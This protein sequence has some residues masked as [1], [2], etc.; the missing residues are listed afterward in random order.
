M[1]AP[2]TRRRSPDRSRQRFAMTMLAPSIVVTIALLAFPLILIGDL[3]FRDGKVT[4][5]AEVWRLPLTLDNYRSVLEDS[6]TWSA[7]GTTVVYATSTVLAAVL[8]GLFAALLLRHK[9]P[10]RRF[11]RTALMIPWPV[12]GAI[13]SVAF[14]WMLDGTYGII[15]WMLMQIGVI[16]AP[17][18]WFFNPETALAGVLLP[19]TWIAYPVCLLIILTGV[20]GIPDE[21]YEAAQIDGAN[22]WQQFR[23]ITLPGASSSI[24]LAALI[25]AL[26]CFTTFDF[27][28]AI[29]RGGPN[30]ATETLAVSIYNTA[31]RAFDLPGA[32]ALGVFTITVAGALVLLVAPLMRKRFH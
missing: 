32:A 24:T 15:N 18:A 8:F 12:P 23:Y 7:L 19:T 10:A 31:F 28:Y 3:S 17:V 6:D 2:Q 25:T 29:T 1:T 21:L 30:G 5:I 11:W 16:D 27:V 20:Q 26:W 13:A 22:T 14:V 9:M 4:R